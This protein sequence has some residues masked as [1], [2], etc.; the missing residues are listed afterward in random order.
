MSEINRMDN[1]VCPASL[2]EATIADVEVL[3]CPYPTYKFLRENAPIFQDP[4][5]GMFVVTRYED[6]RRIALD[7]DNFSNFRPSNDHANLT[8]AARKA[9]E[10]F[11][12]K[13]WVPGDSL[14]A[15]DDPEH[16]QMRSIFDQAFRPKRIREMDAQVEALAYELIEGFINDGEC[17]VVA[18]YAVPLPLI[19]ICR[20]MG[21]DMDHVWQIKAWT[22]A[23]IK[24]I[25][26][27]ISEEDKLHYTD[28]EIQAQHYFQ[29][30]FEQLRQAPNDTLLSDLVNLEVPGWGRTLTD[31]ELHAEMMQDTFVG[32][33]ETTT[34]AI[35]AGIMLLDRDRAAWNKLRSDPERYL[36]TF[37]DEVV[38]LESPAQAMS[39]TAKNDVEINGVRI[40]KGAQVDLRYAAGNRDP[41]QFSNPDD[42]DL[43]RKNAGAHLG[44]STGTHYCLGAPLARRELYWA[45]KA[46]IDNI[47][48]FR[49]TPGRNNLRHLPN[50]SLRI[51][52]E[53]HIEFE[54]KPERRGQN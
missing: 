38:R 32:G 31:N 44:F 14:A 22:D 37:V 23:W 3:E 49:L 15:R 35:S 34:N 51:L 52:K 28:M 45:F 13:G 24:G 16:K 46:F 43:E 21:A 18:Q 29:A 6:Q 4:R 27:G 25:G 41:E 12:E 30:I 2:D 5:T 19:I 54:A 7:Y 39:R 8:G 1:P 10:R 42:I 40:P 47:D 36:K 11:L 17:E 20:Q 26:L 9:Y 48:D 50:Y 53:L 33:S